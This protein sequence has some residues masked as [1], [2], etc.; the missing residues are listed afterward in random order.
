MSGSWRWMSALFVMLAC[1]AGA[2]APVS[3]QVRPNRPRAGEPAPGV[4][5]GVSPA[6]IQRLFDAYVVMQAQQELELTDE[7]YAPFLTRVE[8]A[9]GC[10]T[11][12]RRRA[13]APDADPPPDDARQHGE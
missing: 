5:G 9:A 6:E 13:H 3:A 7:Q 8:S 4:D 1:C 11:A 10:P 2:V 12:K